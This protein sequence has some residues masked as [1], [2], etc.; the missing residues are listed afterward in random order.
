MQPC[1][2]LHDHNY[3][4]ALKRVAGGLVVKVLA[5]LAGSAPIM[6]QVFSHLSG[7]YTHCIGGG[8]DPG[9]VIYVGSTFTVV[10][11]PTHYS[12]KLTEQHVFPVFPTFLYYKCTELHTN[13]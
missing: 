1:Y 10:V 12:L 8:V 5:L 3:Y 2:Q 7:M 13:T 11:N 9:D 6:T 4:Y